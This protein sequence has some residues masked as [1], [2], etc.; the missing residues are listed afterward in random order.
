MNILLKDGH[1][2]PLEC[3][4]AFLDTRRTLLLAE[5]AVKDWGKREREEERKQPGYFPRQPPQRLIA[6]ETDAAAEHVQAAMA[7]NA[8]LRA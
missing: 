4:R 3:V 5:K 2:V 8:L 6:A 7:L 1:Q